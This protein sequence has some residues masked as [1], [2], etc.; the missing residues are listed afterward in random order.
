MWAAACSLAE[1]YT[2]RVLFPGKDNNDMLRA[3]MEVAGAFPKHMLRRAPL[4]AEN[5]DGAGRLLH[6]SVD[7]RD[8]AKVVIR[9]LAVPPPRDVSEATT[10][11]VL[12]DGDEDWN[13][14]RDGNGDGDGDGER[15]YLRSRPLLRILCPTPKDSP[16]DKHER[17][18]L[19]QF[20]RLLLR[21]LCLDPEK[22][23]TAA[24]VLQ[25]PF[26]RD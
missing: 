18:L 12:G 1:L 13:G 9:P 19:L 20:S 2:G 26:W 24:Q 8:A 5:F 16:A 7:P 23:P 6:R 25:D 3:C 15:G 10:S 11:R 17:D 21:C 4:A 22:R 14:D